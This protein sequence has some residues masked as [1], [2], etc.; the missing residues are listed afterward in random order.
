[1]HFVHGVDPNPA[2]Q[3]FAAERGMRFSS[4]LGEALADPEVEAV[5]LATPHSLH[6]SQIAQAVAA[7]KHVFAKSRLR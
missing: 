7:G 6:Q 5:I 3:G 4:E 2:E 1:M